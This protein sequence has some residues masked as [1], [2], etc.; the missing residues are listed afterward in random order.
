VR[1]QVQVLCHVG[2]A[3]GGDQRNLVLHLMGAERQEVVVGSRKG[4]EDT[5]GG[6]AAGG[7]AF[8]GGTDNRDRRQKQREVAAWAGGQGG[9]QGGWKRVGA[10]Q[11]EEQQRKEGASRMVAAYYRGLEEGRQVLVQR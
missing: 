7:R 9:S 5:A 8:G 10:W 3:A 11:M 2:E 1:V 6:R 4:V